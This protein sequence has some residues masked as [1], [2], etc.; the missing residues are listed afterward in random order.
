MSGGGA[1][2]PSWP[3]ARPG[4]PSAATSLGVLPF[5][6]GFAGSFRQLVDPDY[7]WHIVDGNWIID[8][9][10][11]PHQQLVSWLSDKPTWASPEWLGEVAMALAD[12]IAGPMGSVWLFALVTAAIMVL[13]VDLARLTLGEDGGPLQLGLLVMVAGGVAAPVLGPRLQLLTILW[14]LATVRLVYGYLV[15]GERR[16]I[17]LLPVVMCAW[18]NTHLPSVLLADALIVGL[19]IG[20]MLDRGCL[21][22]PRFVV[23]AVAAIAAQAINAYGLA[24]YWYP[25]DTIL[26]PVAQSF[27]QEWASPDFHNLGFIG[28]AGLVV[29]SI[30]LLP[31]SGSRLTFTHTLVPAGLLLMT[32]VQARQA[33]PFAFV[34]VA[35]LAPGLVEG[36]RTLLA[37]TGYVA[38]P[39][40]R[41]PRIALAGLAIA[42]VVAGSGW[43]CIVLTD[44]GMQ[45]GVTAQRQPVAAVDSIT[46]YLSAHPGIRALSEYDWGGYLYLRTD[47]QTAIYGSDEAFTYQTLS[48]CL[49]V[50]DVTRD[51]APWLTSHEVGIVLLRP[52]TPLAVWLQTAPGWRVLY[53]DDQAIAYVP[54]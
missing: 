10:A 54:V 23:V 38:T 51:P 12:R 16:R 47:V 28:L 5:V 25:F 32:L 45:D 48:D 13:F 33:G 18:A 7:W 21:V 8:H 14:S 3:A 22:S 15:A 35:L 43:I 37:R 34:A 36:V 4:L 41:G 27:V 31:L 50:M 24:V 11:V 53:R 46:S 19:A 49:G 42:C 40:R 39:F 52:S 20:W 29:A 9:A 17:W 2:R 1:I 6:L 44:R 26:S 30:V